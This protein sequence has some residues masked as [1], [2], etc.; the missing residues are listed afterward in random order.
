MAS[1]VLNNIAWLA[2]YLAV[3]I[4]SLMIPSEHIQLGS[5][6]YVGPIVIMGLTWDGLRKWRKHRRA[7]NALPESLYPSSQE[8]PPS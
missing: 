6:L 4:G 1:Q 5:W 3:A 7:Q 8:T 2:I